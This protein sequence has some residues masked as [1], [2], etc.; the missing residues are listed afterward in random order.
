MIDVT[1]I[2]ALPEQP[3]QVFLKVPFGTTAWQAVEQSG[4]LQQHPEIDAASVKVGIY[5]RL[6]D[7]RGNPTPQEY[8]LA[9]MDRVEIYRPLTIEP[10]QARLLRADRTRKRKRGHSQERT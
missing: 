5:S 8:A 2:Y 1:V 3:H 7:G 9:D 4:L 10:K 6:L